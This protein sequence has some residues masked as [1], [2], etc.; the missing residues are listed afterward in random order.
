MLKS[1]DLVRIDRSKA[2]WGVYP[3]V[4][5]LILLF[6]LLLASPLRAEP[7][8][9][10]V[11]A[12]TGDCG[13]GPRQVSEALR[14]DPAAASGWLFEV[15]DLAYPTATRERLQECHEPFFKREFFPRR[16]AVPGNHDARDIGLAGFLSIY[17]EALPRAVDFGSWRILM[18]DSNLR[19]EAW[20]R[21]LAWVGDAVKKSAGQCLI[22]AWHHPAWSSGRHNDNAFAQPLWALLAGV[23]SFTL[24]GHDHHY[25]RLAPRDAVGRVMATGTPSFISGHGGASLYALPEQIKEGSVATFKEW[26]YLKIELEATEYRW[27]AM[28]VSGRVLDQG[29]AACR[30]VSEAKSK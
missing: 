19:D 29:R 18:L 6:A 9:L 22:A 17:P 14:K 11:I 24:H 3:I 10:L 16:M 26:G 25:E 4:Q 15:G 28:G 1:D 23:A 21:Q 20:G 30:P 5:A 27:T 8:T 13:A 7:V 2:I 12:D